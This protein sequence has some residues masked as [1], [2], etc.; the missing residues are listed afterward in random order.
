LLAIVFEL[1][2]G[3]EGTPAE[4]GPVSDLLLSVE[5]VAQG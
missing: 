5:A 2:L 1:G 3:L 4:S